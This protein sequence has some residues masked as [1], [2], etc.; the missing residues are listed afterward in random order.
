MAQR[1]ILL[2]WLWPTLSI[3][4]L[5]TIR[6]PSILSHSGRSP[7]KPRSIKALFLASCASHLMHFLSA[8]PISL[9]KAPL[10]SLCPTFAA[11]ILEL[12]R[13]F[14]RLLLSAT[15]ELCATNGALVAASAIIIKI[16][17]MV[18]G[19]LKTIYN[20]SYP[21]LSSGNSSRI[22]FSKFTF[23]Y[24]PQCFSFSRL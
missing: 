2:C 1:L 19:A 22:R 11:F 7:R 20:I 5:V 8:L 23:S 10:N 15:Y 21:T 17:L 16:V 12:I 6:M 14:V 13:I 18:V 24:H 4:L 9:R 3:L